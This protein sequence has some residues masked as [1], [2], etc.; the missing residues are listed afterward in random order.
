MVVNTKEIPQVVQALSDE[1]NLPP[2]VIF[3]ALELALA[4]ATRRHHLHAIDARV[5]IDRNSGDF[6]TFRRW[7]VVM[8]EDYEFP[9]RQILLTDAQKK[10]PNI[11][12]GQYIEQPMKSIEAARISAQT[13]RQVVMQKVYEA[14]RERVLK[15][16]L[17][18]KGAM[19]FGVVKRLDRGD[20]IVD[21]SGVEGL[22]PRYASIPK[23]GLRKGDQIR[24]ILKD[25]RSESRGPQLILDRVCPELLIELFKLEVPETREGL[26]EIRN[27]ARDPGLRA[28]IAVYSDDPFAI[29]PIGACVG[30]RGARVQSVTSQVAGERVDIVQWSNNAVQF[31]INALAPAEVESIVI[32]K[33]KNSM[34]VVV[35]ETQLSQAIG[36]GGQNVRLASQLTGWDLNILTREEADKKAIDEAL[37]VQERLIKQLDV[38]EEVAVR[39]VDN[40]YT[41]TLLI[42]YADPAELAAKTKFDMETA[43][44]INNRAMMANLQ[45]EV[46]LMEEA[47]DNIP[48][49]SLYQVEGMDDD[50]AIVLAAHGI[51]TMEDLA[52]CATFDLLEI[53]G[54]S[55]DR[56]KTLIMSARAPWFEELETRSE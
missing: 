13:V 4:S 26:V 7:E 14:E 35:A 49:A 16:F 8:D 38:D 56:A 2:D 6:E 54:F 44:T 25:V 41:S 10:S 12:F 43:E 17:P 40:G 33:A 36:R 1:R 52:D 48:D 20:A 34:D 31:V 29:D 27:A 15:E 55:E 18:Q 24:A 39:L 42:A 50:T 47:D 23:D 11:E 45:E 28:K 53:H 46:K 51:R 3:E 9:D 22:L 37:V 30:V 19:L 21:I 5:S 32:D